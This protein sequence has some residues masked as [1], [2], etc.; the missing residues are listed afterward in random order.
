M[1]QERGH[2]PSSVECYMKQYSV[3]KQHAYQELNKQ[4]EKAWKG[5]NQE[6]LRPTAIP[7]RLL[8]PVLSFARTGDF[9]YKDRKGIYSGAGEVIKDNIAS[10]FIDPVS[11]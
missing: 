11:M 5:I 2:I 8:T 6:M 4:I 3:S 7:M 10:L 1:E 9:M